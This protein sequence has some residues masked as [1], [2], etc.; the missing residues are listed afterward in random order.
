VETKPYYQVAGEAKD[1]RSALELARQT[2]PDIAIL[3]YSIPELNGLDLSHALKRELPRIEILLYTMHDREEIVMEVLRAGVRGFV[4]KSDTEEHL[5]AAL[6]ALSIHRP[7]FSGA[8]SDTLLNQ[9]LES[10][11][12]EIGE[13]PDPSRA[14]SR[15]AGRRRSDQQGN[16]GAAQHQ[17]Q[18]GRDASGERHAEAEIEDDVSGWGIARIS[19][20]TRSGTS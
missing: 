9:F 5:I 2:R 1:G 15:A 4:L 13:Q 3:D 12:H 10:K 19:S 7:Y 16:R 17:R 6:D 11:P 18:D 8:I 20:A 14:R